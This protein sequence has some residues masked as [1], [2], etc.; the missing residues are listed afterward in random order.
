MPHP[1]APTPTPASSA[2]PIPALGLRIEFP[3]EFRGWLEYLGHADPHAFSL[4]QQAAD[5]DVS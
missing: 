1:Q 4:F 3:D 5:I 2:T